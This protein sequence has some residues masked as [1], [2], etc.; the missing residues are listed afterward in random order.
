MSADS[1]SS[2][3][4][5]A[6]S[7]I[8]ALMDAHN[9]KLPDIRL[10][11]KDR[12]NTLKEESA[13]MSKTDIVMRLFTY[14]GGAFIFGG[15]GVFVHMMW[16]DLPSLPRV[17]ITLGPGLI[18]F[19]LGILFARSP[20]YD[21]ASTP[22]FIIAFLLQ[23]TGLFVLL[24]EY[25]RGDDASLAAM[26]VFGLLALQQ[27]LAFTKLKRTV[28]LFCTI[29]F[30]LGF[31][32][33]FIEFFSL[34][35]AFSTLVIGLGFF[36]LT[37]DLHKREHYKDL[38]P[39]F[40]ILSTSIFYAGLYYYTGNTMLDPVNLAISLA[41]IFI[42]VQQNSKTLYIAGILF[43]ISHA[44]QGPGGG[45]LYWGAWH[46]E[47]AT[48]IAGTSVVLTGL[49]LRTVSFT[50]ATPL[51]FFFGMAF[52]LSGAF[53]I[54]YETPFEILYIDVSTLAVYL[55]LQLKSR[56]A[57]AVA[58]ISLISFIGYFS[59]AYFGDVIAWPLLLIL[60]GF[61]ILG[62]GLMFVRFSR[63]ITAQNTDN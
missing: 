34:H 32:G 48:L 29:M 61:V 18:A 39:F 26:I 5:A 24:H 20:K 28:L 27:G 31:F 3:R 54:F 36:L 22:A 59:S 43:T 25:G 63:K 9:L 33:G 51:W 57:L 10:A 21:K 46:A 49:W 53:H 35:R 2:S 11:L 38:T 37:V 55:S 17:I 56:A 60:T 7:Q 13:G 23:P 8:I 58:T 4:S 30:T 42:A 12:A 14:I 1:T 45:W 40:Y 47:W 6:L 50:A 52:A 62:A 15:L 16:D 19:I 44:L 41:M